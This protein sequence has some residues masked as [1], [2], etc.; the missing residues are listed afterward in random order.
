MTRREKI[1]LV[2]AVLFVIINLAGAGYAAAMREWA[3]TGVHVVL[4]FAGEYAV[5]RLLQRRQAVRY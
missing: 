3:H 4:V 2:A 1:A 5:W